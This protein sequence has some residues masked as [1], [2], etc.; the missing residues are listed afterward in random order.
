MKYLVFSLSALVEPHYGVLLEEAEALYQEG[1][2]VYFAY[3]D[4]FSRCCSANME[5]SRLFC[6]LCRF[7]AKRWAKKYL[8]DGIKVIPLRHPGTSVHVEWQYSTAGDIKKIKYKGVSIGYA[9]MSTYTSTTRDPEPDFSKK[10]IR[11][12]FDFALNN[13]ASWV[14]AHISL[15]EKTQVDAVSIFNGRF[16]E[17][18]PLVDMALASQKPLRVNEVIGGPRTGEPFSRIIYHNH[19]PHSIPYNTELLHK[20]WNFPNESMEEK[21][22]KGKEFFERRRKGIPAGDRVYITKQKKGL[23]P[24]NW[25][26][27]KRNIV[28]FNSSE[29]EFSA[30]GK[31]FDD[32]AF[33]DSQF[34]GIETILSKFTSEEYH[35]YL[36][37]HPNLQ[38]IKF[39]YHTALY[40]LPRK[41][42]NLTVI[43]ASAPCS[44]YDLLDAAEK[45]IVFGS[46][47]GAEAV[48]WG[49]PTILLAGAFY[50]MLDIC[51]IPKNVDELCAFITERLKPKNSF[52]AVQ[53]GYYLL[54]RHLLSLSPK[55]VDFTTRDV[56][57]GPYGVFVCD[58]AR[59]F[60]S[61]IVIKVLRTILMWL[62]HKVPWRLLPQEFFV[63][64][65]LRKR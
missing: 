60:N 5:G 61:L 31:E 48:Y 50:Y 63:D 27:Y 26:E 1:H 44:T 10:S 32:Y 18:R 2:D 19:L 30:V 9:V 16:V 46:T 4:G 33:F 13:A 49:K 40:D 21:E 34:E 53:Y 55:Y 24:D 41:Y 15:L 22:R 7:C 43:P 52:G 47:M 14:E 57:I 17:P 11:K 37:V 6:T 65:N 58:Y 12:Y 56:K 8:S 54:N 3:C 59:F 36:R 25:N 42:K 39:K 62:S 38:R 28:I 64:H 45:V 51:Y 23:L 20:V 29:D 35:F